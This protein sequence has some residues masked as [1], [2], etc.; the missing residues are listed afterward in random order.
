[1]TPEALSLHSNSFY[2]KIS[3]SRDVVPRNFLDCNFEF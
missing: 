1:M 3:K 2:L